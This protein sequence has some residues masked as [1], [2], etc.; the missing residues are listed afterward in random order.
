[1]GWITIEGTNIN[2]PIVK[3]TDNDFYLNHDFNGQENI[4]GSI[5]LDFESQGDFD[6]RNNIIYGHNMKNGSMFAALEKY[7][8]E[9]VS[10]F[11][12]MLDMI[13]QINF[14]EINGG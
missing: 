2:Y 8:S 6:G 12:D 4:A 5:Y 11:C 13:S 10:K 14:E 7:T 1:M 3:G 9:D